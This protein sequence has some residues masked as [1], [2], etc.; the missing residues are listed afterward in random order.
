MAI[1]GGAVLPP[2]MGLAADGLG[3]SR[4]FLVPLIGYVCVLAFALLRPRSSP[5]PV[6]E[7][8]VS[9]PA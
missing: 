2:V 7:A 3:V 1:V 8:L 9:D 4:A 5:R 6:P